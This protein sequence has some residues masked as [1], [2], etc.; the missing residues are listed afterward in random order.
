MDE[1]VWLI[2]IRK[3]NVTFFIVDYDKNTLSWTKIKQKAINFKTEHA[4][5][6]FVHKHLP[7][8]DDIFLIQTIIV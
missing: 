2:A 3:N 5:H 4:V 7:K 6:R 8:R 1:L